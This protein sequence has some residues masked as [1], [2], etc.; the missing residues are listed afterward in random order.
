MIGNT[1]KGEK[2]GGLQEFVASTIVMKK[3]T[4]NPQKIEVYFIQ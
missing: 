1:E 2:K 3:S 4:K